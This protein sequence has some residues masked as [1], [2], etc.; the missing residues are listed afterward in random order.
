MV[1]HMLHDPAMLQCGEPKVN[2]GN[3][4]VAKTFLDWFNHWL[5]PTILQDSSRLPPL[6]LF[7]W[8]QTNLPLVFPTVAGEPH[9]DGDQTLISTASTPNFLH[10]KP[11]LNGQL[12]NFSLKNNTYG[13][14]LKWRYP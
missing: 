7:A 12:S 11:I 4:D 14:F 13:G 9:M 2:G 10:R 5:S 8:L 6:Q 3:R 1:N